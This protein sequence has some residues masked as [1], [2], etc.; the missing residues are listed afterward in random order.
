MSESPEKN[1]VALLEEHVELAIATVQK[2]R[3]EKLELEAEIARLTS[4]VLQR[5]AQIQEL[6]TRNSNLNEAYELEKLTAQEERAGIRQRLEELMAVL[7][8]TNEAGENDTSASV[9]GESE[10]GIVFAPDEEAEENIVFKPRPVASVSSA[11]ESTESVKTE[12]TEA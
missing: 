8:D 10:E 4:D 7:A 12:D 2:L 3:A 1:V 6:E 5:D 11:A 9:D